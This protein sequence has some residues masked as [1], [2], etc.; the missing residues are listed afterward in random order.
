MLPHEKAIADH[1]RALEKVNRE[2]RL[3][4][5]KVYLWLKPG[6]G[7]CS[8]FIQKLLVCGFSFFSVGLIF[9]ESGVLVDPV[10]PQKQLA[11][12]LGSFVMMMLV[13]AIGVF[14]FAK[15]E[16]RMPLSAS[17]GAVEELVEV[18]KPY[19]VLVEKLENWVKASG[20]SVLTKSQCEFL[21]KA[22]QKLN[23]LEAQERERLAC[24][25]ILE[26]AYGYIGATQAAARAEILGQA[27]SELSTDEQGKKS[28]L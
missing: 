13:I 7:L 5:G 12:V 25:K 22:G 23:E 21:T 4:K 24:L 16:E 27:W 9:W 6:S 15:L 3:K 1:Q 8:S 19:P 2:V 18:I 11:V 14:A 28:R 17:A 26:D 10:N 20:A